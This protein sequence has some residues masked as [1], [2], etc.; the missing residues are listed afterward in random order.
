MPATDNLFDNIPGELKQELF[1]RLAGNDAVT[2]ERIVSRGHV[3]AE[4]EWYDQ[5]QDEWVMV[6]KGRAKLEFAGEQAP[7]EMG[8]GDHLTIPAHVRHRVVWTDEDEETVWLAV[9]F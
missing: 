8:P 7:V 5:P 4:G 2:I 6:V 3:S 9:H 1:T